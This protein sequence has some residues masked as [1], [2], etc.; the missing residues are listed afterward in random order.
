MILCKILKKKW[1]IKQSPS[2]VNRLIHPKHNIYFLNKA[3]VLLE[4]VQTKEN[5]VSFAVSA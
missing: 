2:L 1:V 5:S 3:C 4:V